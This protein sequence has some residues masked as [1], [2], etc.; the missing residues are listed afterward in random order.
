[1]AR[2]LV[3]VPAAIVVVVFIDVGGLAFAFSLVAVGWVCMAE[4]Y[5]MLARW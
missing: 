4:L 1:M 3:A 2:I 5:R